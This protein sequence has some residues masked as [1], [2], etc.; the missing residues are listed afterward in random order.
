MAQEFK[1]RKTAA[2]M[3][4]TILKAAGAERYARMV[5]RFV[6]NPDAGD[7]HLV[8]ISVM[9]PEYMNTNLV[10]HLGDGETAEYMIFR[11]PVCGRW[12]GAPRDLTV[13]RNW[14][15]DLY[16]ALWMSQPFSIFLTRDELVDALLL[17]HGFLSPSITNRH[18]AVRVRLNIS[19]A[20]RE[21]SELFT[22]AD[23]YD[24]E[25]CRGCDRCDGGD[26]SFHRVDKER[27]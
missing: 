18:S 1:P 26:T 3:T 4:G 13:Q 9:A 14:T 11:E 24:T 21:W 16:D 17:S 8:R 25:I 15:F 19:L 12:M 7:Y 27:D 23:D 22:S 20:E 6:K 2:T 5:N 10:I